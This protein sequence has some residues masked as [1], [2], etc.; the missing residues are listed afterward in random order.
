VRDRQNQS[1]HG[2]VEP[3]TEFEVD[4]WLTNLSEVELGALLWLLDL[5]DDGCVKLGTG[6]PLGF[7]SVRVR[8]VDISGLRP[9]GAMAARYRGL[10]EESAAA[11]PADPAVLIDSFRSAALAAYA[12]DAG[13]EFDRL[14]FIAAFLRAARGIHGPVHYPRV[15]ASLGSTDEAE[16]YEWFT[17]NENDDPRLRGRRRS[18]PDLATV[19]DLS[20]PLHDGTT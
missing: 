9:G 11:P 4:I 16:S 2:W 18:L 20:L 13:E 14:P 10:G 7:G 1:I 17:A 12:R 8:A 5:P 15:A 19:V 6:R 3:D